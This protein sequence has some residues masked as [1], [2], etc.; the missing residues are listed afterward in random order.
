MRVKIND[1]TG[2][3]SFCIPAQS[4]EEMTTRMN[5]KFSKTSKRVDEEKENARKQ[6]ILKTITDSE[7]DEGN[8]S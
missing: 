4:L 8:S 2:N 7:L 5:P 6:T 1:L 3:M